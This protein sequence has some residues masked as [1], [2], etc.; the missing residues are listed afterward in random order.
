[1]STPLPHA[2]ALS[3][4]S[5]SATRRS[6]S[7]EVNQDACFDSPEAGLF[8]VADGMGGH[9]AGDLASQSIVE[10]LESS[11]DHG[12][13]LDAH[14]A[15]VER[16]LQSVN[17]ALREAA[18]RR[19]RSVVIGSTVAALV[20]DGRHAVCLWAGDSRI[21]LLRGPH[22]YQL[23]EDHTA[24]EEHGPGSPAN[25]ITRA[26][27]SADELELDRVVFDLAPADRLLVCTDGLTKVL[28]SPE[29]ADMLSGPMEHLPERLIAQAA[30]RGTRDDVTVIVV[31]LL[32]AESEPAP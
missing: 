5:A 14:V 19:G 1:M 29:L 11:V 3:W 24:S 16:G 22:L 25:S 23:T 17:T 18:A 20:L 9:M 10:V 28:G 7:R 6:P 12:G 30:T 13:G 27:G 21:Y 4:C 2:V 26:V 8:V 32:A 15:A 31:E